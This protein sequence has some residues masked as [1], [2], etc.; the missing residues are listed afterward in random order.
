MENSDPASSGG[1]V[2]GRPIGQIGQGVSNPYTGNDTRQSGQQQGTIY[3][4]GTVLSPAQQQQMQ[5][6]MQQQ[7][8]GQGPV[9]GRKI[10]MA[11][12]R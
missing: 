7:G 6:Q 11:L 12:L 10:F 4:P 3:P 2:M 5:Q 1:V 8:Q 9:I